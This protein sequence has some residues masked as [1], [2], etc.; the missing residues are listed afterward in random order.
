M[1]HGRT[2]RRFAHILA[3]TTLIRAF[4]KLLLLLTAI[5]FFPALASANSAPVIVNNAVG[6]EAVY[7]CA[8]VTSLN[9]SFM[10]P[11]PQSILHFTNMSGVNWHSLI[12]TEVGEP[13][14][15]ISCT[16]N[17]FSCSIVPYGANGARL[18]L[19]AFGGLPGV[20]A[21]KSFEIGFGCKHDCLDWPSDLEFSV[22]ANG[23][24]PEL[25]T[26]FLMLTGLLAIFAMNRSRFLG[27]AKTRPSN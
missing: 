17:I 1:T 4:A 14:F 3:S 9:F 18:I 12:L 13:A 7:S 25:G 23:V 11:G 22:I 26:T 10:S 21:G 6:C 16:S 27:L 15:D 24:A 20:A 5:S 19:T 2:H 8:Q